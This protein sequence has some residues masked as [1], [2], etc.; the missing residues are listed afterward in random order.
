[1]KKMRPCL[2][3][4]ELIPIEP[5]ELCPHN[6]CPLMCYMKLQG[7]LQEILACWMETNRQTEIHMRLTP[8]H[9][10]GVREKS[11]EKC[12]NREMKGAME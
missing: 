12:K 11:R 2:Y 1:M 7:E 6:V 3:Q 10:E 4:T 5:F 8:S 9:G